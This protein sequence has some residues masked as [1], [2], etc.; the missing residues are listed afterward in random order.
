MR[1]TE[2]RRQRTGASRTQKSFVF[3]PKASVFCPLSF[4]LIQGRL[5][6][7]HSRSKFSILNS[8]TRGRDGARPSLRLGETPRP[9]LRS[10]RGATLPW[11]RLGR[12]PRPTVPVHIFHPPRTRFRPHRILIPREASYAYRETDQK[13]TPNDQTK[14]L[15]IHSPQRMDATISH[16]IEAIRR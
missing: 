1:T 9:T 7:P 5:A 14:Q 13:H 11:R 6:P 16:N 15:R 12:T 2:N 8:Q 10:R 4:V 3:C